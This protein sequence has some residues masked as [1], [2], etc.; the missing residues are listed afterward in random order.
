MILNTLNR[1]KYRA[2]FFKRTSFILCLAP[3]LPSVRRL[4][5][6]D[7]PQ[8]VSILSR[9]DRLNVSKDIAEQKAWKNHGLREIGEKS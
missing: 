2:V 4:L 7:S 9:L 3:L 1:L 8:R 5:L 6:R